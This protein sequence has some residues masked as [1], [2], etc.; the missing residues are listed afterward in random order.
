MPVVAALCAGAQRILAEPAP[1]GGALVEET[2]L[3]ARWL[4][5]V[6]TRIVE[7]SDDWVPGA[8]G[9]PV[10]GLGGRGPRLAKLAAEQKYWS[11]SA[12]RADDY[13]RLLR[14]N[15]PAAARPPRITASA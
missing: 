12:A 11:C 9:R 15:R 7:V 6:G 5:T 2:A 13:D 4:A 10:D 3:L 1:L 8:R 14:P